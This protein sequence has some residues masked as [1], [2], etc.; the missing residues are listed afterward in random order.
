MGEIYSRNFLKTLGIIGIIDSE[1]PT[2]KLLQS[3]KISSNYNLNNFPNSLIFIG[4]YNFLIPG[5]IIDFDRVFQKNN[6]GE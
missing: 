1:I 6:R 4:D 2:E 5:S 3:Y